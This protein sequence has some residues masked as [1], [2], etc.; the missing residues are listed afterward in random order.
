MN[1]LLVN[2]AEGF[3]RSAGVQAPPPATVPDGLLTVEAEDGTVDFVKHC[4][5]HDEY[6]RPYVY[7]GAASDWSCPFCELDPTREIRETRR[8]DMRAGFRA[9]TVQSVV[10][11]R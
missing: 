1:G 9:G 8:Q 4:A 10:V 3:A 6:S 7:I 2:I 5:K 11:T